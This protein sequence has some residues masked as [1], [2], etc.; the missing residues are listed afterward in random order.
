MI[1]FIKRSLLFSFFALFAIAMTAAPALAG[2]PQDDDGV[3]LGNGFPSGPHFNLN[4]LGKKDNFTCPPPLT[5]TGTT[6]GHITDPA[7]EGDGHVDGTAVVACPEN[8]TCG[9]GNVIFM[10]RRTDDPAQPGTMGDSISILVESGRKGPKGKLAAAV[11]EVT[12]LCTESFPDDGSATGPGDTGDPA[13]FRLPKNEDGYAVYARIHGKPG[14]VVYED[15]TATPIGKGTGTCDASAGDV[16]DPDNDGDGVCENKETCIGDPSFEF[17]SRQLMLVEDEFGN[18]LVAIGLI[19]S[20]GTFDFEGNP[21]TRFDNT[22]KGKGVRKAVDITDFFTFN[23]EV[24]FINDASIQLF[25]PSGPGSDNCAL[26]TD[27]GGRDSPV[28]CVAANLDATGDVELAASCLE[29]DGFALCEDSAV[30][31]E[32]VGDLSG[33]EDGVC[34]LGEEC[35]YECPAT[36]SFENPDNA[37]GDDP[38]LIGNGACDPG[39][40]CTT[41]P[42]DGGEVCAVVPVC[43]DFSEDPVWIFNLE[44]FVNVLFGVDNN[45]SYNVQ[46]RFYPLPLQQ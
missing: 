1:E 18:D 6:D 43:K 38:A 27:V 8:H 30:L 28:C 5:I 3:F 32:V 33:N 2:K 13:T 39:E 7:A 44:A 16:C 26:R 42:T 22:K 12:D 24:C 11:L 46:L 29:A 20:E 19:T 36:I 40:D 41:V 34:D 37:V 25:C 17:T 21:L 23:G 10:P 45:G 9:Y 4:L 35:V 15:L 31:V 14:E